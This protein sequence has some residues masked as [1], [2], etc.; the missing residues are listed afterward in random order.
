M[1]TADDFARDIK[2]QAKL[3][4]PS[5]SLEPLTIEAKI[6]DSVAEVISNVQIDQYVIQY[7]FDIDAKF[8]TDL[9][10]FVAL[11]GFARRGGVKSTGIVTFSRATGSDTDIVIKAGT[12]VMRPSTGFSAAQV[13]FTTTDVFLPRSELTVD[14]PIEA[15]V[16]GVLGNVPANT[17]IQIGA[18]TT[19]V[20][21]VFNDS[22]TANGSNPETDAELKIRF[23]NTLFRNIAGTQDQYLALALISKYANKANVLG[24]ISRYIEYLQVDSDGVISSEIPFSKYTYDFDYY[25][26]DGNTIAEVFFAPN[27]VDYTFSPAVPPTITVVNADNLPTDT[28]VLLEHS[29]CSKHS[30]NEPSEDILHNVDIYVS[31]ENAQ[32]VNQSVLF[33]D[34]GNNIVNDSLSKFNYVNF[35]REDGQ[36]AT[37]GSRFQE[38]LWQPVLDLPTFI[39]IDGID[40]LEGVHY[41][42]LEDITNYRGSRRG[43]DG[44]E[45]SSTVSATIADATPFTIT[46]L[47][48]RVPVVL[49]ELIDA[50]KQI[51]TDVLV[52]AANKRYFNFNFIAMYTPGSSKEAVD[53]G[54]ERAL[55]D[56]LSAQTFGA[57]I[58]LSDIIEITHEVAGVD[59]IKFASQDDNIAYGILEVAKDGLTPVSEPITADFFLEDCDLPVLNALSVTRRAQNTWIN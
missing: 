26:T 19:N 40:Y 14:A 41:W 45:W 38:L 28:I 17:I 11:F 57:I 33:P 37:V 35:R 47:L 36:S 30:R 4:D 24:P 49:N 22:P 12:Q 1:K 59:N 21:N 48:N 58:Q 39:T 9:D 44:I 51:A 15:A 53:Q 18:T 7:Q 6:V 8:G 43:R 34:S 46:Y 2:A 42:F 29:Y 3:L 16:A 20:S 56:F 50:H 10:K 55:S 52:H 31:G 13:F 54:I 25:L 5:I 23:K 32:E 27:G